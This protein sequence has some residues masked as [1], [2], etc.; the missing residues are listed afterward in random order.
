MIFFYFLLFHPAWVLSDFARQF[1][2][3]NVS[4]LILIHNW[5]SMSELFWIELIYL[6]HRTVDCLIGG[7]KLCGLVVF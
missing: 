2:K 4:L 5:K 6:V 3:M 7:L 1:V